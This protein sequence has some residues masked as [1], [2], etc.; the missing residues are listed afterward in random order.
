MW[1]LFVTDIPLY[2]SPALS[3]SSWN[4]WSI[5]VLSK[6]PVFTFRRKRKHLC[7]VQFVRPLPPLCPNMHHVLQKVPSYIT[8]QK[9]NWIC[10]KVIAPSSSMPH[11]Y[12]ICDLLVERNDQR[13][14]CNSHLSSCAQKFK[15][16]AYCTWMGWALLHTE[17]AR[18]HFDGYC[19]GQ[20][21]WNWMQSKLKT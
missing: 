14:L 9:V 18:F 17:P 7:F 12:G 16:A 6:F 3:D 8:S 21:N 10:A 5:L 20:Y 19:S 4:S 15:V 13:C 1:C 2:S 11:L